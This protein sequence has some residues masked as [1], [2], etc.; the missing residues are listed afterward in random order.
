MAGL[1]WCGEA[2]LHGV[3]QSDSEGGMGCAED[4]GGQGEGLG[5]EPR[6]PVRCGNLL[7]SLGCVL[8]V[9]PGLGTQSLAPCVTQEQRCPPGWVFSGPGDGM[10]KCSVS[11]EGLMLTM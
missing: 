4:G 11:L 3:A 2:P 5:V 6:R 9:H 1:Y 10:W 8:A 7:V